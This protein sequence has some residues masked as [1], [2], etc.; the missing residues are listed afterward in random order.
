[1]LTLTCDRCK[2]EMAT[3]GESFLARIPG[4]RFG[5]PTYDEH[6]KSLV[7]VREVSLCRSCA[8]ELVGLLLKWFP[9]MLPNVEKWQLDHPNGKPLRGAS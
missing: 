3:S 2:T 9:D 1:M 6:T 5:F 7:E 8:V 4:P